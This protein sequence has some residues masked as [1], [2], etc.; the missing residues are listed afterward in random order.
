[1]APLRF[2]AKGCIITIQSDYSLIPSAENRLAA[3]PKI[4]RAGQPHPAKTPPQ[5]SRDS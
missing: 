5:T 2:G 1:M 3:D 4:R